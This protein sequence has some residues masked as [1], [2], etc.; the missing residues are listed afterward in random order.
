[1]WRSG[2]VEGG[3][4]QLIFEIGEEEKEYELGGRSGVGFGVIKG[5]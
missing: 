4:H 2:D 5:M 3:E 1:M